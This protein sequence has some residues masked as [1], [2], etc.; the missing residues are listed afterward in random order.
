[1]DKF[2]RKLFEAS[3]ELDKRVEAFL[4]RYGVR[5]ITGRKYLK[6]MI[7]YQCNKEI[8]QRE[9]NEKLYV[10]IAE[11]NNT[12]KYAVLRL[13]RYACVDRNEIK[14]I[15]PVDLMYRAWYE[16][17]LEETEEIIY[18]EDCL[19]QNT[20]ISWCRKHGIQL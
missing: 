16:V 20:K 18:N 10:L 14:P 6:Q 12:T 3:P 4:D 8:Y 1:M 17:K 13:A 15:A 11:L 7:V 2:E 19:T 5:K 9:F